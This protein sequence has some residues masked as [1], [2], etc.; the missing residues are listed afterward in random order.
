MATQPEE[1]FVASGSPGEQRYRMLFNTTHDGIFVVDDEDRFLDLNPAMLRLFGFDRNEFSA[2]QFEALFA[3]A[4][5]LAAIRSGLSDHD[6]IR[7]V[8]VRLLDKDGREKICLLTLVKEGFHGG[9]RRPV[10][11]GILHDITAQRHAEERVKHAAMHDSLT[12]LPNRTYFLDR[13]RRVFHRMEYQPEYRFAVLFLDLDRFKLVNDSMGHRAGDELLIRIAELL[14]E[15]VRPEDIVARFG[16]DEFTILLLGLTGEEEA[17][18][19]ADRIQEGLEAEV[20]NILGQELYL[21]ASIGVALSTFEYE[22]P[23]AMIR[24]ADTAMYAAKDDGRGKWAI[25]DAAMRERTVF[26]FVTQTALQ[27]ALDHD[28]F[29][30]HYQPLVAI[31]S[32]EILGFEA[33]LRWNHPERGILPPAEFLQVAE[34]TRLIIP[35][36]QW[37]LR[38]ACRVAAKW[39]KERPDAPDLAMAVNLSARQLLVPGFGQEV[40][41]VLEETGLPGSNLQLEITENVLLE[42]SRAVRQTLLDLRELGVGLCLDDFGTGYSSLGYLNDLPVGL[43]KIDRSFVSRVDEREGGRSRIGM[44]K[45]ILALARQMGVGAIAEGVETESQRRSLLGLGCAHAQGFLFSRP[46][47]EREARS[48]LDRD[49]D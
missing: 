19:V 49:Q 27:R 26:R 12:E 35:I 4:D 1:P 16:G 13:L 5:Q 29:V 14:P 46:V 20:F 45:T 24:D 48:L 39:R 22:S 9:D 3:D 43:L 6:A 15:L 17:A 10:Y 47:E 21:T 37:V 33:L 7:D 40:G 8:E 23:E 42:N 31:D 25:F 28:E 30:L 2:L 34:E 38:E 36:G 11:H 41:S 18:V 44:V 32:E